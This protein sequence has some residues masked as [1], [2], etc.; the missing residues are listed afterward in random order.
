MMVRMMLFSDVAD[1]AW[2]RMEYGGWGGRGAIDYYQ[3]TLG[4]GWQIKF[5]EWTH[6]KS[7]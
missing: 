1:E 6:A 2:E 7:R 4:I 5:W 3:W